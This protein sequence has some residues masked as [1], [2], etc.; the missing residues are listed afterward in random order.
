M[1]A[2]LD[3]IVNSVYY[4][5]KAW[6]RMNIFWSEYEGKMKDLLDFIVNL[7]YYTPKAWSRMN[8]YWNKN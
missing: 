1:K 4:L 2:L 7:V 6:S 5:P 3:F 8:M